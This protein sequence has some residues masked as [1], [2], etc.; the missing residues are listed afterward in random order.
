M[1]VGDDRYD[2]AHPVSLELHVIP[3]VTKDDQSITFAPIPEQTRDDPPFE[4]NATAV[5]TG[6]HHPVYNLPVTFSINYGPATVDPAGIVTLDGVAGEVSVT[7][8]QSGSAYVNPAPNITH[9]FQVTAKQRQEIRFPGV[10]DKGGV[11]DL[12]MLSL[13]HI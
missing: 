13:I 8:R 10:G 11:R 6:I 5:S 4:L 1:Q 12:P 7:A 9:I 3:P 2:P